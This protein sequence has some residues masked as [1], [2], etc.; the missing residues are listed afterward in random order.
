MTVSVHWMDLQH[1]QKKNKIPG[2]LR[3]TD[4]KSLDGDNEEDDDDDDD[5]A[6]DVADDDGDDDD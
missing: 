6:D 1:S 3:D 5:V 2:F 4:R